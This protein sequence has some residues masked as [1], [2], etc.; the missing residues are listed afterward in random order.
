MSKIN[1]NLFLTMTRN[2]AKTLLVAVA[3]SGSAATSIAAPSMKADGISASG[4]KGLD[5]V[6]GLTIETVKSRAVTA[7]S[8]PDTDM[9][10]IL[11]IYNVKTGKFISARGY[12]GTHISLKDYPMSF[13][14]NLN[15]NYDATT[16]EFAQNMN[17]GEGHLLGWVGGTDMTNP[18]NGVFIDRST[19]DE[20][21]YGWTFEAMGDAKNT[22]KIYTYAT[23]SPSSSS[24]KYYLC[25]AKGTTEVDKDCEGMTA[26]EITTQGLSGY[27]T[28]RI[29]SMQQIYDLQE[30]NS[31]DMVSALDMSF[32]LRSPGFSRGNSDITKWKIM[33]FGTPPTNGG[34][35]HGL[36]KVH[37]T[38]A[39]V[40]AD[41]YDRE[42]IDD[43]NPYT[44]DGTKYTSKKDYLRNAA[45]YF[46]V[47]AKNIRG[48]IYQDIKVLHSGSYVVECKG[49]SNTPKVRLFAVRL[50]KDSNKVTHTEHQTVLS[51]I[52]YM[53]AAEKEA[54]H[55]SEQ[56]MDY[57]GKNFYDS[58][59]YINSVL[60]QVPESPDGEYGYI[61]F[62]VIIGDK[63]TDEVP[64]DGE[65]TVFDDFRLLYASKTI[66]EDLILDE[67]RK[68]LDY[69]ST[70]SNNYKNKVLHLK[71]T[72]TVNKWNT[73]VLPVNLTCGQFRLAFGSNARLA[74]LDALTSN[75]IQFKSV[76]LDELASNAVALEAYTPYIFLPTIP[77]AYR[78][79]PPYKALL[80]K[81]GGASKSHQV[82]VA[83]NHIEIPN[84]TMATDADNK[85]D[86]SNM[87]TTTWTT[88]NMYSVSGNGTMEARGTF[89]RTFGTDDTQN[90]DE[91][92]EDYGKITFINRDI[93]PGRD[94]LKGSY[95][96]DKGDMYCSNTRV[97][98][99]R[100]FSCWF[101][102]ADGTQASNARLFLDGISDGTATGINMLIE[103]GEEQ[104]VGKVAPGIYTL[105]GQFVS[106]GSDTTGLPAGMYIVNG[107]K[108]VVK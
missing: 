22:Y 65:W 35:R 105:G 62:G 93:I 8:Y 87:D 36:E 29:M 49:Y 102:P 85:N 26:S 61:R 77:I 31:D 68:D 81:T 92:S 106:N 43:N 40:D 42:L 12:W 44:F 5:D 96:F 39:K 75:E 99:L 107:K 6:E 11:F 73:L 18:D 90:T 37:N 95:F 91:D 86:L 46:C 104:P 100:G 34:V 97:R 71:K 51:Q 7:G 23:K 108:C 41:T 52:D 33:P 76:N 70:C 13:W 58:H 60:V 53:S 64:E 38:S 2:M 101:K 47:D 3:I 59:K 56:N 98:G 80:T 24:T 9:N 84:V 48:V 66:D 17:T 1:L 4:F 10:K 15:T 94:N 57:A 30:M 89:A 19:K 16:I 78:G 72:F 79:T 45:K 14:A 83:A 82:V 27:D 55:I 69:L 54:L 21:H 88:K 32:Q 103:Y 28:W 50:D 63:D 74:R 20:T 67:D 25:A